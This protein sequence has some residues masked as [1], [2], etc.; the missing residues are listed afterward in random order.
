MKLIA[1]ALSL[2]LLV[3]VLAGPMGLAPAEQAG[4]ASP[5]ERHTAW[6]ALP[7]L[8]E[9]HPPVGEGSA[10]VPHWHPP[11]PQGF[12]GLPEGHPPVVSERGALP[13]GHPV[14]PQ[15]RAQIERRGLSPA[16]QD[17]DNP[18]ISI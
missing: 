15:G 9:G 11:L 2:G 14:C 5:G 18:V 16:A 3:V 6:V 1:A 7:V 10:R 8:P 12:S 4:A 17:P 13:D